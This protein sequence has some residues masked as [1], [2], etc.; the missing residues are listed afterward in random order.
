MVSGA[1]AC[2]KGNEKQ[3]QTQAVQK[4]SLV[5]FNNSADFRSVW[6]R[7]IAVVAEGVYQTVF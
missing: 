3:L 6:R 1:L 5:E 7:L 2:K 4:R